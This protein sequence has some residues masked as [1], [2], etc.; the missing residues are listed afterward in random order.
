MREVDWRI[1]SIIDRKNLDRTFN[2]QLHGCEI[3]AP[4]VKERS[5]KVAK[6]SDEEEEAMSAAIEQAM[7]R[8]AKQH[9]RR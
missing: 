9:V 4:R 1:T 6:L 2:A 7:L 5:G 8:K 3:N